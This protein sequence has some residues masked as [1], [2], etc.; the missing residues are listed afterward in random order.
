VLAS[1]RRSRA[2]GECFSEGNYGV[3]RDPGDQDPSAE[4]ER[5]LF[6]LR[7][8]LEVHSS[9]LNVVLHD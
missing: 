4:W 3:G 9:L 1:R 8:R 7:I 2:L 5:R 6:R